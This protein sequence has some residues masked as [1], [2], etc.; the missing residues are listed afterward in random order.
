VPSTEFWVVNS[1]GYPNPF[2]SRLNAKQA[3]ETLVT[4]FEHGSYSDLKNFWGSGSAPRLLHAHGVE[5]W[6]ATFEEF[7]LLYVA[8]G[9]D[10]IRITPAGVQLREAGES[11][12]QQQFAWVGLNLLLRYPL[13]GTRKPKGPKHGSSDLLLYWFLYAAIRELQN[14]VWWNELQRVLCKV[15]TREEGQQAVQDVLNL[16]GGK[17]EISTFDL[18]VEEGRGRF[19]NS[20]NQVV[21]HAGMNYLLIDKSSD[22]SF[23]E[24]KAAE[25]KHWIRP[26]MISLVDLALGRG[27]S[28][29]TEC[30]G[31]GLSIL[32]SMPSAPGFDGDETSLFEYLGAQV[33]EPPT[34]SA[35]IAE[36]WFQGGTVAILQEHVHYKVASADSI[37][38]RLKDLCQ[39][40]LGQRI[41][42]SH[43][44]RWSHIIVGKERQTGDK[45]LVFLRRARPVTNSDPVLRVLEGA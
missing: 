26:D 17:A 3:W 2:S 40:A 37:L 27:T 22:D 5:S 44:L 33:P 18:P 20:L 10:K 43:N 35:P 45:I 41:L 24:E 32:D 21:V 28:G 11:Q 4:F 42:L 38:G 25:R 16:R 29:Q 14:Y 39:L 1:Y 13:R 34:S 6:K 23:Y 19:Y 36:I 31:G 8:S 15:F 7:G 12:E 9:E 30:E